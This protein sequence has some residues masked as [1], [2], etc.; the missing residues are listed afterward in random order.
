MCAFPWLEENVGMLWHFFSPY[1]DANW[2][3]NREISKSTWRV[4]SATELHY[5]AVLTLTSRAGCFLA[6]RHSGQD[7]CTGVWLE[8]AERSIATPGDQAPPIYHR[9]SGFS[10][11]PRVASELNMC[12]KGVWQRRFLYRE[13]KE[14]KNNHYSTK[15]NNKI[16][17]SEVYP[18][19]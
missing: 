14:R 5:T 6:C 16:T 15:I 10:F 3:A 17:Y 18:G 13:K 11:E 1:L 19:N 2:F 7:V 12:S 4:F 8:V 9:I